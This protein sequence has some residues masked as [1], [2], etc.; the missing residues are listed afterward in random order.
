M[1]GVEPTWK[2]GGDKMRG[3]P[4]HQGKAFLMKSKF[5]WIVRACAAAVVAGCT[6]VAMTGCTTNAATGK[7][8]YYA[9]SEQE[10]IQLGTEAEPEFIKQ[11]GGL[12]PSPVVQ[13]YVSEL[14][15]KLAKLT[16]RPSLPWNF[17]V[18][19][20]DDINAFAIPGGKVFITRGLLSR[21]TN[22]AQLAGVLGHECGHVTGQHSGKQMTNQQGAAILLQGAQMGAEQYGANPLLVQLG[23]QGG[24][25][26]AQG[27]LLKFGRDDEYEADHLGLR[28]M[29]KAGYNPLAMIQVMEILAASAG[30]SPSGMS[31]WTSTHPLTENRIKELNADITKAYPEASK[32]GT[33]APEPFKTNVLAPLSKLPPAPKPAPAPAAA[34]AAGAAPAAV[35]PAAKPA[36]AAPAKKK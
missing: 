26:A 11:Y 9:L 25:M 20:S 36:A 27:F 18:L 23:A 14:G 28:Y 21:M 12:V 7:S 10:E 13:K 5:S 15:M 3:Y 35:A 6:L 16:E 19:N 22:E 29:T 31:E 4:P 33:Y 24:T 32:T 30:E 34:P 17:N 8:Y 2:I 1:D